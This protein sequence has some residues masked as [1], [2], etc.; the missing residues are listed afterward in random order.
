MIAR[1]SA[2][3]LFN[4]LAELIGGKEHAENTSDHGT[5]GTHGG[6]HQ[7]RVHITTFNSP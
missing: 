5:T 2:Y 4:P 3:G 6:R 1:I 7:S